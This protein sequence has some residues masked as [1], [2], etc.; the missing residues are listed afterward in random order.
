[1]QNVAWLG[2]TIDLTVNDPAH[3]A[4]DL[5]S[6]FMGGGIYASPLMKELREKRGLVYSVGTS[7]GFEHHRGFF[8]LSFGADPDKTPQARRISLQVLDRLRAKPISE[9]Q[10]H[11]AKSIGLRKIALQ[12]QSVHSIG[13]YWLDRSTNDLPLDWSYV[14]AHHYEKLTAGDLQQALE[15]YI[16]PAR[17]STFVLGPP[18]K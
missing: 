6:D 13:S 17:L 15:K 10:L 8:Y 18:A 12:G 14:M 4:L 1:V 2:E 11:L 9:K 7:V 16:D 5:A 3:F